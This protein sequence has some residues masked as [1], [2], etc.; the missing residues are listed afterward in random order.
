MRGVK[1]FLASDHAGFKLKESVKS[2]LAKEKYD[3]EDFGAFSSDKK[4]DYPDF[5]VPCV[6]QS[7]KEKSLAV[8]IG[9]S[10]EGEAIAANKVRGARAVVI[11]SL[12]RKII[13]LTRK[14]NNSNVLSLGARFINEKEA[15]Q[16][17]KLWLKT[18]FDGG[19]HE[20]RLKKI[21]D[22]ERRK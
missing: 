6:K 18:K 4:D 11:Y 16:I 12:N 5:V 8:I 2:F 15:L 3:Y 19:R 1:I 14:H 10:G 9:G 17:I 21:S 22:Y 20:R 13:E 7:V